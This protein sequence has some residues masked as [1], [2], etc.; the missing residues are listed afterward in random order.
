[1]DADGRIRERSLLR[2]EVGGYDAKTLTF[3]DYS[4]EETALAKETLCRREG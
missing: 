2:K 3:V 4:F 1:M